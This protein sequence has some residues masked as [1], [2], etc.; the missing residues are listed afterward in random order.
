MASFFSSSIPPGLQSGVGVINNIDSQKFPLI[1]NRVSQC[2]QNNSDDLKPFSKDEEDKLVST[3]G[4]TPKE[5]KLVLDCSTLILKQAAFNITK[6]AI[7]QQQLTHH[8][9]LDEDKA[10]AFVSIW[11]NQAKN[12]VGTLK[13]KSTHPNQVEGVTWLLDAAVGSSDG[14]V[15]EPRAVVELKLKDSGHLRLDLNQQQMLALY[16]TL[17]AVQSQLD[18]L[19]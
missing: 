1:L 19:R 18:T 2:I 11:T 12:I 6:P 10:G 13:Q 4:I 16:E 14:P 3:L 9:K 17:E 5:L 15:L 8:L 7:L